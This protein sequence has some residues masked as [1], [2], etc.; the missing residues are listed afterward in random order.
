VHSTQH[1]A[2]ALRTGYA[3]LLIA[4]ILGFLLP[5]P[6]LGFVLVALDAWWPAL[7][8]FAVFAL[9]VWRI[10][11]LWWPARFVSHD[12]GAGKLTIDLLVSRRAISVDQITLAV[13]TSLG[14]DERHHVGHLRAT[15]DGRWT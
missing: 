13:L 12:V 2:R 8:T 14:P 5:L 9:L 1:C 3:W 4:R 6:L 10:T 11:I 7:V 15:I